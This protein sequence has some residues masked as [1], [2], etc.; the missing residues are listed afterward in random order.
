VGDEF[1]ELGGGPEAAQGGGDG[2][3]AQAEHEGGLGGGERARAGQGRGVGREGEHE[4][5][6][7]GGQ[8]GGG[9]A[10]GQQRGGARAG[11]AE[12]DGRGEAEPGEGIG[13]EGPGMAEAA[14]ES[15]RAGQ[16]EEEDEVFPGEFRRER[17]EGEVGRAEGV[18]GE[19]LGRVGCAS[20]GADI[21]AHVTSRGNVRRRRKGAVNKGRIP[22]EKP[23]RESGSGAGGG[24]GLEEGR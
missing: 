1:E 22:C 15:G 23:I 4:F 12:V 19:V 21:G 11:G 7:L 8:G 3:G 17:G 14:G 10:P 16:G 5:G 20:E 2:A 24:R 6:E 13:R 9:E 18:L